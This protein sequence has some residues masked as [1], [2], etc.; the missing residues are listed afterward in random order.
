[1]SFTEQDAKAY[2]DKNRKHIDRLKRTVTNLVTAQDLILYLRRLKEVGEKAKLTSDFHD[3]KDIEAYLTVLVMSYGR[4]F[5]ESK[6]AP[7]LRRKIIP[8]HLI[9]AHDELISLRHERYAHHGNHTTV[10]TVLDLLVMENEVEAKIQWQA[11]VY[12]GPAP[13]WEE[14]FEWIHKH[15]EDLVT[16]E[17]A[18]LSTTGKQWV[19][20]SS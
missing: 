18:F 4:L 5:T 9:T 8:A 14:L 16:K 12:N 19:S 2:I 17:F 20:P 10:T 15:I 6:G 7:V 11:F 1:M 3:V 13:Q